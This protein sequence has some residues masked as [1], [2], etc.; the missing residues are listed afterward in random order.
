[1][2]TSPDKIL[3]PLFAYAN[4]GFKPQAINIEAIVL[5]KLRL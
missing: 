2:N 1:M 3:F 5:Q 4:L